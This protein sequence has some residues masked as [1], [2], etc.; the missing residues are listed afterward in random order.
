MQA[1]GN[2]LGDFDRAPFIKLDARR[3]HRPGRRGGENLYINGEHFDQ[4]KRALIFAFIYEG[5]PNWAATDGVV[6]INMP[7]QA[8]I[9]V[10]LD[11]GGNQMMCAIAMIENSG[12][13]LQVTKLV[14][15]FAQQGRDSAHELMDRRFGFGL[16]WKTGSKD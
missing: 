5:A 9:E 7:D 6:T 15:Y 2:A 13:N 14:E 8:P 4:I 1:L 3:P 16:R 12:G 11:R 10:R